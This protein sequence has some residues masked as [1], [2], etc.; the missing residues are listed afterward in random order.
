MYSVLFFLPFRLLCCR[1]CCGVIFRV[2]NFRLHPSD[3]HGKQSFEVHRINRMFSPNGVV[4]ANTTNG[5]SSEKTTS[6]KA[7]ANQSVNG[8][9]IGNSPRKVTRSGE[10]TKQHRHHHHHHHHH[11]QQSPD[12]HQQSAHH[13]HHR[14]LKETQKM[15]RDNHHHQSACIIDTKTDNNCIF[16]ANCNRHSITTMESSEPTHQRYDNNNTSGGGCNGNWWVFS[17]TLTSILLNSILNL[18]R[19]DSRLCLIELRHSFLELI[20]QS[21]D[22]M[23]DEWWFLFFPFYVRMRLNYVSV[24]SFVYQGVYLRY[25]VFEGERERW[26]IVNNE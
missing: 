14:R 20:L 8:N 15:P 5:S 10:H 22:C 4:A 24:S 7:T 9:I 21:A 23:C 17:S 12:H 25:K 1:R 19:H 6:A 16:D 11:R 2:Q 13:H 26:K 18:L 3:T